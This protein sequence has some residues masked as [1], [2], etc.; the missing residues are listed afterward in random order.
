VA[1]DVFDHTSQLRL[2]EERFK[3]LVPNL[4]KW[5]RET[6]G[7][8]TSA[9]NFAAPPDP[10]IPPLPNPRDGNFDAFVEGNI[11]I[12]TGFAGLAEPYPV[13]PNSMPT[14]DPLPRRGVP[15]GVPRP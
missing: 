9:F 1:S 10:D 2:I 14:Q 7:A 13:P 8:L 5:R 6:V 11:N 3:V 15:S 12:L 4:T